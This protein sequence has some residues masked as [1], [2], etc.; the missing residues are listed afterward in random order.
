MDSHRSLSGKQVLLAVVALC[1]FGWLLTPVQVFVLTHPLV[2][3]L[4]L[5][6]LM[7]GRFVYRRT[8]H[9]RPPT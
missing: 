9:P 5:A 2:G 3:L 4:I 6:A 1:A 7:G 8:R